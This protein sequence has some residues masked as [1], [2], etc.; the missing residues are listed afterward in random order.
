MQNEVE[1]APQVPN[2]EY[3]TLMKEQGFGGKTM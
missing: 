2:V 1:D 3:G